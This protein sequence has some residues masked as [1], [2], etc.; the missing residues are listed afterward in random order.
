MRAGRTEVISIV[1]RPAW[2]RGVCCALLAFCSTARSAAAPVAAPVDPFHDKPEERAFFDE[3]QERTFHF[4]WETANPNNGLVPDR[5]PPQ[6]FASIASV[7]FALT[8]YPIGVQRGYIARD[9]ARDR[10]L[11]TLRF[12]AAAANQK[13]FYYHFMDMQ[14]GQRANDSE[15]STVD[16]ALLLGGVLLCQSYF[17][18]QDPKEV[19]IRKLADE[20]YRRVDWTWAQPRPP[21][22]ALSW[23]PEEGFSRYDWRGYNEA[24]LVYIL[25]LGS[26][27][28]P[29]GDGAWSAWTGTYDRNWGTLYGQTH[30]SFAP[31]FGHQYTHV[32]VDFRGIRD[33]YMQQH[34]LDYFENSR[35][36]TFAQRRYA[37]ENP[38]K[39]AAYGE[40]IWG[41]SA[42]DGP[43]NVQQSY[44]G[45]QRRFYRYAGRGVGLGQTLDD[46]TITPTAVIGSL[47][48]APEIAVPATL[49]MY[50]RYGPKIYST[51]GFL[52]SFNPSFGSTGWFDSQYIG[53]DQG[54]IL[55]MVENYRSG[56]VWRVMRDN[57]YIRRGLGR[58][59]FAGGWIGQIS[60]QNSAQIP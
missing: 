58:A 39:W 29:V 51:Y 25:A 15:V 56:L 48:F 8:A 26:P 60:A 18:A 16:T 5:F 31:L 35:R 54:P 50:H 43:A 34:G 17:T 11:T 40:N 19:E 14:S 27:T 44:L 38:M 49:E 6:S 30:L 45:E 23:T 47:P 9:R 32:W 10:V 12:F 33:A 1:N 2:A 21:A 53:I 36:A 55:A 7:G 57:P 28:H 24:M 59:G 20:I 41:I 52:D 37:I 4:F 46:G 22:V 3:L 13:G 42:C